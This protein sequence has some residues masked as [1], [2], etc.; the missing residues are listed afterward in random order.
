MPQIELATALPVHEPQYLAKLLVAK[1]ETVD[2]GFGIEV[3]T[4][5][6]VEVAPCSPSQHA[7]LGA[8]AEGSGQLAALV[9]VLGNRLAPE[10]LWA[11]APR[12]SHVPERA[13]TRT[14]PLAARPIW[15]ADPSR[16]R[17]VRLL[18]RP[19]PIQVTA[20]VPDDPPLAFR[21]RGALHC[22]RAAAGPERIAAEWWHGSA[23]G[24]S[25]RPEPD[26]LRDYYRIEDASGSRFWVFRA[27]LN[28]TRWFLHGLFG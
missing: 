26:L 14:R 5:A 17:P 9:D 19:E 13:I 16:P 27:G 23:Q 28:T 10:Q 25:N 4:L 12:E 22:V 6:A 20:P 8:R 11:S 3:A 18:R 21:W 15:P 7:L 1:L 2:P 24:H